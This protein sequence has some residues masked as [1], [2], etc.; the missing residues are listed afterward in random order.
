LNPVTKNTKRKEHRGGDKN[1]NKKGFPP[2][3][4]A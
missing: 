1:F 2:F 4:M 3:C